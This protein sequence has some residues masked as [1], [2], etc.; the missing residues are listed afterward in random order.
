MGP[1]MTPQKKILLGVDI[2]ATKTRA[3]LADESGAVLGFGMGGPGNHE[4]VGYPGLTAALQTALD[5]ACAAAGVRPDQIAAAGFGIGGLDW[6]AQAAETRAAIERAGVR[7]PLRMVNDAIIGLVAGAPEGWGVA[8]VSG[9]GCNCW[10]WNRDRTRIGRV[11]GGGVEMGE[12]AGATELVAEALKAVARSWTKRGP[13]T[14]LADAFV[15]CAGAQNLADLLEGLM[16]NRYSVDPCT[17]PLVFE[18][19][20]E[21]DAVAAGLIAWAGNELGE[22]VTAVARQLDFQQTAFDVVMVGSMFDG[23]GGLIETMRSRVQR[24]APRARLLRLACPP[25]VGAA[26]LAME[27][28]G[29]PD[30]AG[31]RERLAR[32]TIAQVEENAAEEG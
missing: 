11:T 9:T 28:A 12:G 2:G 22:M 5:R 16:D 14:V 15:A 25:V 13:A 27:T 7:A 26:L 24:E 32:E 6:D 18:A 10:G 1:A 30:G 31:V 19:A 21:G 20:R 3:L 17:A 8:V 29:L 4:S 23:G